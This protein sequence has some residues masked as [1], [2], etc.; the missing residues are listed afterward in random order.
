MV[1]VLEYLKDVLGLVGTIIATIP[2]YRELRA[3]WRVQEAEK[4]TADNAATNAAPLFKAITDFFR[5]R[6][7]LPERGD[8]EL[9]TVGL[10]LLSASFVLSLVVTYLK[11]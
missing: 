3:K 5:R 1:C 8:F 7:F 10:V 6:L 4:A 9:I 11:S 2:F